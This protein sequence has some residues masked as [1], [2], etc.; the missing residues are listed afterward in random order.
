MSTDRDNPSLTYALS[1]LEACLETP[2]VPG[3]LE[4][5]VHGAR[6]AINRVGPLLRRQIDEVHAPQLKQIAV[7]DPGLLSR[8]DDLREGDVQSLAK[9]EELSRTFETLDTIVAQIEPDETKL[10]AQLADVV[11]DG[12]TFVIHVRT[13]EVALR[14]WLQEAFDRDRGTVD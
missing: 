3:E 8:A 13:Q 6:S 9:L 4:S 5:W 12:L 1:M 10:K 2:F 11:K 14:T 7:E